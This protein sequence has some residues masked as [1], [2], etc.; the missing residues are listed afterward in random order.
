MK[1]S[2]KILSLFASMIT[3]FFATEIKAQQTAPSV[4]F[5]QI[6]MTH[7]GGQP[8]DEFY[9]LNSNNASLTKT[10]VNFSSAGSYR[11]DISAYLD[12]GTPIISVSIDGASKGNITI[13]SASIGIFSLL[14]SNISA[15]PHTV[16]LKLTNFNSAANYGKVGL[17]YFTRTSDSLPYVYPPISKLSF[18]PAV[19]MLTANHFGSGHLRGFCL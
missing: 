5:S 14:I 15:G 2:K 10:G 8:Y 17:I 1:R 3:C 16:S 13:T 18:T 4:F 7:S 12:K 9:W 6:E 11:C 19:T